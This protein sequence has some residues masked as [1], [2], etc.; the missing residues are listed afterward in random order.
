MPVTLPGLGTFNSHK[1]PEY[2]QEDPQTGKQTLFPP[3]ITY[4]M[5]TED[6][7]VQHDILEKQL[8]E[9]AKVS[10]EEASRF[11]EALVSAIFDQLNHGKECEV[12][13]LGTFRN[14]VTNQGDLQRVAYMPD[15]QMRQRVNAPF[16]CF[17]PV[18]IS[19]PDAVATEVPTPLLPEVDVEPVA[20]G[21]SV[22][23]PVVESSNVDEPEP[24]VVEEPE[25]VVEPALVEEPDPVFETTIVKEPEPVVVPDT[26]SSDDS[27]SDNQYEDEDENEVEVTKDKSKLIYLCLLLL[28]LIVGGFTWY[29]MSID[30]EDDFYVEEHETT[31]VIDYP[32]VDSL[33][34]MA[35][36]NTVPVQDSLLVMNEA[37][38]SV[39][40]TATIAETPVKEETAP[41]QTEV[42]PK[43]SEKDEV[44]PQKTEKTVEKPVIAQQ[45]TEKP[46]PK[47]ET[48]ETKS[49]SPASRRLKNADGSYKTYKLKA[50]ERLTLVALEYYGSKVFWPYIYEVN[51]D[52]IKS[53]GMVNA[54]TVLYLP[55][56]E[57]F[58]I[59][60]NNPQSVNKAKQ[61]GAALLK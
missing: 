42:V 20:E 5:Q 23:E 41:V 55:D 39:D 1:H 33:D 17:E 53:P 18:V 50:G 29:V 6:L 22:E 9:Q 27:S 10:P 40:N 26:A 8:A 38:D 56:P 21:Q 59:D 34:T 2:I 32:V 24:V 35:V 30:E 28:L 46:Q 13:G 60:A 51:R 19:N 52:K 45:A 43:A 36:L 11:I 44:V 25:P 31:H 49:N 15:E 3:R 48:K 57:A 54:G 61:A 7:D 16:N 4:R 37:S 47:A 58:G 12:R 14:V